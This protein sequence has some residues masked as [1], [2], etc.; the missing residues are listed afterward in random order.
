MFEAI[1]GFREENRSAS[2]DPEA[3]DTID[4]YIPGST[5]RPGS[6]ITTTS[7]MLSTATTPSTTSLS[8]SS[9]SEAS[10]VR[11][12]KLVP[13][14]TSNTQQ[15]QRSSLLFDAYRELQIKLLIGG[16]GKKHSK[17]P[18]VVSLGYLWWIP[19]FHVPSTEQK[20]SIIFDRS[21]LDFFKKQSG[22]RRVEI[23]WA[24]A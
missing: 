9:T 11:V 1:G 7:A 5:S 4:E 24:W 8:S 17:L 3:D 15:D 23:G 18:D 16:H 12:R 14:P 2:I 22:I 21:E 19:G 20:G 13:I 10:T 6:P